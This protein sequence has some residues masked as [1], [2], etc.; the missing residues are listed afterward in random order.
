MLTSKMMFHFFLR[1]AAWICPF[2]E[3]VAIF[4]LSWLT[5][6]I[7]IIKAKKQKAQKLM[8]KTPKRPQKDPQKQTNIQTNALN[9][10][11]K[12]S[13]SLLYGKYHYKEQRYVFILTYKNVELMDRPVYRLNISSF[14]SFIKY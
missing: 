4:A 5:V 7:K 2:R 6:K 1:K 10:N 11:T 3:S 9:K 8:K 14:C 12:K 13:K